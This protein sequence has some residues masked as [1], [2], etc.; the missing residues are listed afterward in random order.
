MINKE[1]LI[2]ETL[3]L[4]MEFEDS[5][6]ENPETIEEVIQSVSEIG[7]LLTM[8]ENNLIYLHETFGVTIEEIQ[9]VYQLLYGEN[10]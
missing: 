9:D 3:K 2:E 1:Q 6:E 7:R 10:E 8:L 4:V 5:I